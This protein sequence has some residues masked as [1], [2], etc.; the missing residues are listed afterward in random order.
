MRLTSS[1][2]AMHGSAATDKRPVIA[3]APGKPSSNSV[4]LEEDSN[5]AEDASVLAYLR[6]A[7]SWDAD[8]VI[9]ARL[10][11]RR[12]WA[13]TAVAVA[14][15]LLAL[16]ALAMLTPLKSVEPYLIR[17]DNTTGAVEPV[18]LFAGHENLPEVVSR[19]FLTHYVLTCE[20]YNP[21]SAEQDYNECG[22]FHN[23]R[24]NQEWYAMWNRAN[25][26]SPLNQHRDGS[27]VSAQIQSISFLQ[28][29][30]DTGLAQ[31]RF[32]R[33]VQHGSGSAELITHWIATIQFS[34]ADPPSDP[35]TR[36]WNPLGFRVL[37]YHT[38][39]EV[40][41]SASGA[42]KGKP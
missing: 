18:P 30:A 26:N 23:A 35:R 40:V 12:A 4:T 2:Y 3:R 25:P 9:A 41:D 27:T 20:R 22:A 5:V 6:E 1:E 7:S 21:A 42:N 32:I 31:V 15:A 16:V 13:V 36:A 10:Q 8:S 14:I 11:A 29:S 37:D 38:E 28:Q 33:A 39:P 19:Y 17:V 34:Y 24:R